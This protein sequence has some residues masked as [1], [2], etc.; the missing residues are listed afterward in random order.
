MKK[1]IPHI[2]LPL[3]IMVLTFFCIDR[4]NDVMA[5]MTS[6]ISK[7]TIAGLAL[8]SLI[9]SVCLIVSNIKEKARLARLEE[10]RAKLLEKK[11]RAR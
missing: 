3:S 8:T 4:V 11:R 1:I 6:E 9:T 2:S 5:F 7:W 10:K